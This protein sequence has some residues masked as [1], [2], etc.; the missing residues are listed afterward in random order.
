MTW[1]LSLL[2]GG[3]L[4]GIYKVIVGPFLQAYL[5]SKD[6]DLEKHKIASQNTTDLAVAVLDANVKFAAVKSQYAL[7]VLQ[8]WP[9][10][11][12]LFVM[13]AI[14]S[15][16]FCLAMID[17]TWWWIFG[18]TL[19][20]VHVTGDACSWSFPSMKGTYAGAEVQY[21]LFFVIAKPVDT[22][23]SGAIGLVSRYL[24]K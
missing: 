7:A 21:I 5:K 16:R 4:D 6:V 15:T 3:L 20:G 13:L 24:D 11:L 10:R 9:F 22:A 17:S 12:I 19:K 1:L 23:V 14:A 2:S 8:W 18:C